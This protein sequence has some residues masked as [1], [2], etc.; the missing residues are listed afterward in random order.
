MVRLR[1][2]IGDD[3]MAWVGVEGMCTGVVS[4]DGW[5]QH[6]CKTVLYMDNGARTRHEKIPE[7]TLGISL[8]Y[9]IQQDVIKSHLFGAARDKK[10]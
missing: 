5:Q 3:G 10:A 8:V 2:V 1:A 7:N 6:R 4:K 9:R